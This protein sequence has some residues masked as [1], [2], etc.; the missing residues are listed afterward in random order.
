MGCTSSRLD[1]LPAVALCRER[2]KFLEE[3]IQQ[4]YALADA[5]VAYINSLKEIGISLD[6]FF[7]QDLNNFKS[8]PSPVL[9]LPPHRKGDPDPI[10][11]PSSSPP[12]VVGYHTHHSHS[13]S[14]SGSHLHFHTDDDDDD[15]E[16]DDGSLHHS[17]NSSPLH[18]QDHETLG[19]GG[20]GGG[21][22]FMSMNF[23]KKQPTQSVVYEQRP[24]SPD[25]VH[26]AQSSYYPYSYPNQ[27]NPSSYGY[28]NYPPAD[29]NYGYY[30]SAPAYGSSSPPPPAAASS[31]KPPPPP[32]SPPRTSAWDFLNPF[33]TFGRYYP[34]TTPSRDS[35]EVR[36]EE[37]IPDLEDENYQ[38]EVVKEVHGTQ[39]FADGGGHNYSKMVV[40][41]EKKENAGEALY[42]TRPSVSADKEMQYEVHLVDKTVIPNEERSENR[43]NVY[44]FRP[45]GVTEVLMVIRAQFER[46]SESGNEVSKIL[47][48][49]KLPY[50]R[51]NAIY[52]VSSKMLHSITPSLSVVSSQPSTS[53]SAESSS[54]AEKAG[55]AYLD[56]E[57]EPEMSSVKL[58]STL[59]KLYT[60]EKKLYAEV[61]S[62][63]KMRVV[64]ERKSKR[65]K[66]LA[67]KGAE[68]NKIESTQ[69]LVRT[70]S[71]KIRI[72]IQVVDKISIKI[73][74]LRDE[75]LWPQIT[76][77]INGFVRMWKVMLE[78][79]QSQC[80][81][82]ADAK[83]LDAYAS[84]RKL[85][86]AHLEAT[87]Q[88]ELELLNW[89]LNF[90]KW[91]AAQKGYIRALNCWLLKC[92]LYEPEETPDGIRPF[93]PSSIGAPPVFVICNQWAQSMDRISEKD[94]IDAMRDFAMSV[95]HRWE[96][97]NLELRQRMMAN[98]DMDKKVKALEREE[99]KMQKAVQAMDKQLVLVSRQS[100]GL[101]VH[102]QMVHQGGTGNSSLQSGLKLIFE[103]M[104]RFTA[105]SM[106]A[107][108][109]LRVRIEEDRLARENAKVP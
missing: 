83:N 34:P 39:K 16:D 47:E 97:H 54:S 56:F 85:T 80:R 74:K 14:N 61:K 22:G 90:S 52:Q 17:D 5:H 73:N 43:G 79:H 109:Q 31:S 94:V 21:G 41:E 29:P 64:H 68:A 67:E 69:T 106:Q 4:R 108:E 2:C 53:K 93:S 102:G 38:D 36:E 46:A 105:N 65:L 77:L 24:M 70:L 20:G 44:A 1:D 23:M 57:G 81:V 19:G 82:V 100:T 84:N 26:M 35:R 50:H 72:A 33:E 10:I 96:Q 59:Q 60:W 40:G 25:T 32:P 51:R 58:S 75:E 98:K 28:Y 63:E 13:H 18:Y 37:G 7:D 27:E 71:T 9:N 6:R 15:D 101:P 86:D 92:L 107:Y 49:G 99:Q 76:E 66:H 3:A 88:L 45:R 78:C 104:E 30:G 55:S 11:A 8:L 91:I 42:Q 48:A 103:A 87:L 62:E 89:T 95:L 12:P